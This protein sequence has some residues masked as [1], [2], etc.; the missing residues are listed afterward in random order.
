MARGK[1]SIGSGVPEWRE[2]MVAASF[3][4][5]KAGAGHIQAAMQQGAPWKDRTGH[6]RQG[7]FGDAVLD[8]NPTG[9]LIILQAGHS[10]EYGIYLETVRGSA[11]G[12][13]RQ[14]MILQLSDPLY[15][16][17]LAIVW[18]TIDLEYPKI[19]AA[20]QRL[21]STPQP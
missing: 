5:V 6:A 14:M 8:I 15:A 18:P 11:Y 20:L 4:V 13:R 10:M 16:G 17:P 19:S 9:A 21:W 2:H 1:K 12:H 7:L 3:A